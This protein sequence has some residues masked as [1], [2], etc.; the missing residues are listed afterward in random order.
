MLARAC[1]LA[2]NDDSRSAPGRSYD[3][4][5]TWCR[6]CNNDWAAA[7]G[8]CY[9]YGSARCGSGYDDGTPA[10]RATSADYDRH[11]MKGV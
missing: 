3:H 5:G 11:D 4:R 8:G 2:A 10:G 6:R 1:L 7:R 9:N